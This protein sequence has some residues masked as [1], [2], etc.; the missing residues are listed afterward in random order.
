MPSINL[1]GYLILTPFFWLEFSAYALSLTASFW[2]MK[3]VANKS[4]RT[5][6]PYFGLAAVG[7]AVILALS[8]LVELTYVR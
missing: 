3:S 8:A 4:L 6:L 1:V 7:V 5:E 2:L